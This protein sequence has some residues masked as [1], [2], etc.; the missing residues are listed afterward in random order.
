VQVRTGPTRNGDETLENVVGSLPGLED[1][2]LCEELL[3]RTVPQVGLRPQHVQTAPGH[4]VRRLDGE[5]FDAGGLDL[6][7]WLD[8]DVLEAGRQVQHALQ[9]VDPTRTL[10]QVELDQFELCNRNEAT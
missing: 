10:R 9:S 8:A 1:L 5:L 7:V 6:D 3:E 2:I 4:K